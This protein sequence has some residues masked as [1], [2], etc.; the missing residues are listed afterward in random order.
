LQNNQ[1]GVIANAHL[2]WAD[3]LNDGAKNP[4][5][6]TLSKLHSDAVDSPKTGIIVQIPKSL[7]VKEWPDFMQSDT[8]T[9]IYES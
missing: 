8:K 2:A 7:A 6:L 1:L 9:R 4:K 5:C 3:K